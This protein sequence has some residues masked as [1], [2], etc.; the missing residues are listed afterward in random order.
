MPSKEESNNAFNIQQR[1]EWFALIDA[2]ASKRD[3]AN[4]ERV[5]DVQN[6]EDRI[7]WP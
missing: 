7:F 5:Q 4:P 6:L 1:D 3:A 2:E